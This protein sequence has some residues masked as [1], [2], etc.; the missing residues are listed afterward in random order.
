MIA[1]FAA[2]MLGGL[3]L[4]ALAMDECDLSPAESQ[5]PV[6][7]PI[8][9]SLACPTAPASVAWD[10]GDGSA[11]ISS[12]TQVTHAFA[13][14]GH[15][16]VTARAAGYAIL[17]SAT[18]TA[19]EKPT[20]L[21][22]SHASSLAYST[23]RKRVYVVN[24]DHN[25][26]AALDVAGSHR[27]WEK[28]VGKNP[29][30]LALA[31]D[32]NLWVACQDDATVTVL[33]GEDGGM[34]A[35]LKLPYASRPYGIAFVPGGD[36]AL[37][38]LEATGRL[39]E[40][41]AGRRAVVDSLDLGM[42]ARALAISAEGRILVAR[43]LSPVDH[44]EV[45]EVGR[46]P[47]ARKRTVALALDPGPDN[48]ANS[49][50]VPN[51]LSDIA[52]APAGRWAWVASKKDNVQRGRYRENLD[53]TF[54]TSVRGITS[55][56]DM[57][58]AGESLARRKDYNDQ[59]LPSA[60]AFSSLGEYAFVA[61]AASN[62]VAVVDAW[63]GANVFSLEAQG[64]ESERAPEGLALDES[65]SLLFV[66][67]FLSRTVGVWDISRLGRDNSQV[68]LAAVI[69]TSPSE[70]LTPQVLRGKRM[71]YDAADT[72]MCKDRYTSCVV[73]HMDGATDGRVW[74]FTQ[75][76]EG[77][78]R[79]TSLLGKAGTGQGPV[80]WSANFDEIQDFE[81]DMR[82]P[83]GGTG[84]LADADFHTA[85]RDKPLGGKKA[86]VNAD[87]DALAAY[88]G[89]LV[90]VHPSPYRNPDGTLSPAAAA[91]KAIFARADVGCARCHSGTG[92]TDSR[93]PGA[94][95][96]SGP[97]ASGTLPVGDT[98][99]PQG[100]LV[101]DVGTLGAGAGTRLGDTLHGF[102]TPTLL[103][104][105][106]FPPYLHDGSAPTLMDVI[107]TAN[108]VDRHGRT[109]QLSLQEREQ[110]VAYLEQID[111]ENTGSPVL[112]PRRAAVAGS[113]S[114]LRPQPGGIGFFRR[115]SPGQEPLYDG[116][117]RRLPPLAP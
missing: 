30:T 103:G 117:G 7:G 47:L 17:A 102:D 42:H 78:R 67:Y 18:H 23:A 56:I 31:P 62:N 79:T 85:D 113:A 100:F 39:I 8:A 73:C 46:A 14:P 108:P 28:S 63:S 41:D 66:R 87:L 77:L 45:M 21:R 94:A 89:S 109:S 114:G 58:S 110:L 32:G 11:P 70:P 13:V 75:R 52:I 4:A 65:D 50:G 59:S 84:F 107:T 27:L 34:I 43:F 71:F 54:E 2:L 101:H 88:V 20:L 48:E 93:L 86:G 90:Q 91:G 44:G 15:Y 99:T 53:L 6:S 38:T 9:F 10:F 95:P 35:S 51:A 25:T 81:H 64:P 19:Y 60:L 92:F 69:A 26:V 37:V 57:Q 33:D 40:I 1:A 3:P 68:R 83:F 111:G 76:G 36:R 16:L 82:G 61:Q 104:V 80:H 12:S 49:R 105:W 116:R 74:D 96:A 112:R 22:P 29:R 98:L 24:P 5:A 106:E 97:P 55:Q 72:R 115:G